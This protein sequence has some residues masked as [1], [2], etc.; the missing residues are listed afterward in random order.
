MQ[1]KLRINSYQKDILYEISC[2]RCSGKRV[3]FIKVNVLENL[4]I[5]V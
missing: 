3:T 2:V 1:P 5:N 4:F